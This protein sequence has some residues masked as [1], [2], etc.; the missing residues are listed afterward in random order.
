MSNNIKAVRKKIGMPASEVARRIGMQPHAFRRYDR[1]EADP[2]PYLAEKIAEVL[3][4]EVSDLIDVSADLYNAEIITPPNPPAEAVGY[5]KPPAPPQP[6][7]GKLPLYAYAAGDFGGEEV[8]SNTPFDHI[9]RPPFISAEADAYAV[10]VIGTSMEPR[11]F[12][13]EIVYALRG[14]PP[15]QHDFV[16]VQFRRGEEMRAMVKQF[17][18]ADNGLVRLR[19]YNPPEDTKLE[20]AVVVSLDTIKGSST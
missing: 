20:R 14:I 10:R 2:K 18:S 9:D 19:Q 16:V 17:V 4:C 6:T 13:G 3:D 5:T 1:N 11:Y 8:T 7:R 12:A 15:R